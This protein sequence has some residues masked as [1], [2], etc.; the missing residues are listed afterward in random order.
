MNNPNEATIKLVAKVRKLVEPG[1]VEIHSADRNELLTLCEV[2]IP[3]NQ[4]NATLVGFGGNE[5]ECVCTGCQNV[6]NLIVQLD[7]GDIVESCQNHVPK[8]VKPGERF[9]W[10]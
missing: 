9:E 6:P 2:I 3:T 8:S 7:N 1:M 10:K 4:T 5:E